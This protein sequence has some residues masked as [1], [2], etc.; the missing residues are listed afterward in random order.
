MAFDDYVQSRRVGDATV[1]AINEGIMPWVPELLVPEE[2]WRQAIE[3]D[4]GGAI[5]IAT[6]VL[7]VQIGDARILIDAGLDDPGSSW[8]ERWLTEYPGSTLTRGVTQALA[9]AGLRREDV[10]HILM[11]H[12]H[13]DHFVGLT[14][15]RGSELVPRYP[16]ARVLLGRADW[17]NNPER[18]DPDS[19]LAPRIGTVEK[20]GLL[21]LVEG[22]RE[23]V[24]GVTM[25]PAP[26]ESPGHSIIRVSSGG[27]NLYAVG[28]L[29][30]HASEIEHLD[31]IVP[32]A[33]AAGMGASRQRL[34]ED[35]I[36]TDAVVVFTH[37]TFP[38][39]GRIA[40]RDGGYRW[41]RITDR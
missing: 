24:P 8:E 3:T 2:E 35:A 33:D 12:A 36:A 15:E 6:H 29:F 16:N 20:H 1:T 32:W 38:P 22:I 34:L 9:A 21:E 31:W 5:R 30:H 23:V 13:F 17:E 26:G 14:I 41:E 18:E 37:E 11:T 27:E 4:A 28:D 19:D 25:I 7:L 40:R 10:T 39:W